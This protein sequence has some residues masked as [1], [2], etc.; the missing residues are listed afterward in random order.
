[1]IWLA[2]GRVSLR[3]PDGP[4]TF[5][6]CLNPF[7]V[8][9]VRPPGHDRAGGPAGPLLQAS[10]QVPVAHGAGGAP[11]AASGPGVVH[12]GLQRRA[13]GPSPL[14]HL[15][16]LV[17]HGARPDPTRP[18]LDLTRGVCVLMI[19]LGGW[20][21]G[22]GAGGAE[23]EGPVLDPRYGIR[24]LCTTW[25][26]SWLLW[27]RGL[28]AGGCPQVVALQECQHFKA[29]RQAIHSHLGARRS[30]HFCQSGSNV[31]ADVARCGAGE[32]KFHVFTQEINDIY[33]AHGSIALAVFGRSED[34]ESGVLT[35]YRSAVNHLATGVSPAILL[36][37]PVFS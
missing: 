10:P 31:V 19:G 9:A 8:Q 2:T 5:S 6:P 30:G 21:G 13:R 3:R 25:L 11:V 28:K 35:M 15:R 23:Q 16:H 37:D 33:V 29:V 20:P 12:V 36:V 27:T 17:E 4:L 34:V 14:P 1:M 22:G 26:W 18:T 7:L 32:D 24:P